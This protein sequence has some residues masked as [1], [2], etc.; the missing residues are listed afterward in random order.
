[1]ARQTS[2]NRDPYVT[3]SL[4][5]RWDNPHAPLEAQFTCVLRPSLENR[6]LRLIVNASRAIRRFDVHEL[7]IT[8]EDGAAPGSEVN[9]IAYIGFVEFACGGVMVAGDR[10]MVNGEVIGEIAGFDE[11]HMPNH[12]NIV[13]KGSSRISGFNRGLR[14]GDR[15]S[16]VPVFSKG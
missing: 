11:T 5:P 8:D 1:M 6:G 10:V 9:R 14:L 3:G 15:V 2:K 12:Q 7:I 16:F 4:P 13:I